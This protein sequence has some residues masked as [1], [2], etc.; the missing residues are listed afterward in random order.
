MNL[1]PDTWLGP[2]VEYL[3]DETPQGNLCKELLDAIDSVPEGTNLDRVRANFLNM[4]QVRNRAR[5][6]ASTAPYT[7]MCH[8][9]VLDAIAVLSGP[10]VEAHRDYIAKSVMDF[11]LLL[12]GFTVA[13]G[14]VL[15]S[16][17]SAAWSAASPQQAESAM[18]SARDAVSA[19]GGEWQREIEQQRENL[20]VL[21]R[22]A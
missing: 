7:R 15:E 11:A 16:A 3:I 21:L 18:V 12:D 5:L 13:P 20:T 22:L 2:L 17:W 9:A 14:W 10:N 1:Q 6:Q 4:V 8:F 19:A